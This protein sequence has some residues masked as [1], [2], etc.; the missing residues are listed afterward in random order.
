MTQAEQFLDALAKRYIA[1]KAEAVAI[2]NLYTNTAV[3]V[4][5]HPQIIDEM[6][7]AMDKLTAADGKLK[8]IAEM[9]QGKEKTDGQPES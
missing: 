2:M 1:Q 8:L 7:K 3:G 9:L 4:G 5:E 6:D